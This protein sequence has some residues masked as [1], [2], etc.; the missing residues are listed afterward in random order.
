MVL[1]YLPLPELGRCSL[2]CRAWRELILSLDNTRWRELC[3]G[4]PE[5]PRHPNWPRY[6]NRDGCSQNYKVF[7]FT[8]SKPRVSVCLSP[9]SPTWSPHP[10]E[11]P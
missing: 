9:A 6:C 7:L 5:C 11:K 1:A 3:L 10:G 8:F 2:V 4:L